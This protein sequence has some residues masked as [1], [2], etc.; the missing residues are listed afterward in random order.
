LASDVISVQQL[1]KFRCKLFELRENREIPVETF[2]ALL[3]TILYEKRFGPWFCEPIVAGLKEDNTPFLS[4]M[5]LI[6][7]PVFTNGNYISRF[8]AIY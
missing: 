3:S 1:L 8:R 7:A 4:G 5:D 6:G 2:S